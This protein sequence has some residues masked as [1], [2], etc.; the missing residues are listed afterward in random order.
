MAE[1]QPTSAVDANAD[2]VDRIGNITGND[3]QIAFTEDASPSNG[4]PS[5]TDASSSITVPSLTDLTHSIS[6]PPSNALPTPSE[7]HARETD[8]LLPT[9]AAET[10]D[11]VEEASEGKLGDSDSPAVI[12][13]TE[14]GPVDLNR[15]LFK[16]KVNEK[17]ATLMAM[18]LLMKDQRKRSGRR[19]SSARSVDASVGT[20]ANAS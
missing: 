8:A 7:E 18:T 1:S 15:N 9:K 6:K 3:N 17:R 4:V 5:V 20:S 16:T 19:E 12:D 2:S 13:H 14:E 11:V 10:E